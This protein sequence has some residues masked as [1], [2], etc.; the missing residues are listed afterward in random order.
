MQNSVLEFV[1]VI[2]AKQQVVAGVNYYIT[3]EAKDGV[4]KKE[5]EAK[6]WVRGWLNS[7]ELLE[8]KPVNVS[9]TQMG[10]ITDVTANSLEIDILARFAVDQHNKKEVLSFLPLRINMHV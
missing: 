9:S 10:G 2:S 3:L 7:K 6:I 5:Y 1:R 4:I 8:F